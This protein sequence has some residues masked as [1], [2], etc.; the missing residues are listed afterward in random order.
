MSKKVV[1]SSA[2]LVAFAVAVALTGTCGATDLIKQTKRSQW[3][4]PGEAPVAVKRY[5]PS[6]L[7]PSA[8]TQAVYVCLV[9]GQPKVYLLKRNGDGWEEHPTLSSFTIGIQM[10]ML[11]KKMRKPQTDMPADKPAAYKEPD[12]DKESLTANLV[13]HS[14]IREV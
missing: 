14:R 8:V 5:L 4:R 1:A 2:T 3:F 13:V 6:R 12:T 9:D 10:P 7:C 11:V